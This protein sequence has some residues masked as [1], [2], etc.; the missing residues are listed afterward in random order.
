M[1]KDLNVT[2]LGAGSWGTT[3]AVHLDHKGCS[4]KLWEAFDDYAQILIETR[5]NEKYLPNTTIAPSIEI[6]SK[7]ENVIPE[8]DVIVVAI[9][10]QYVR[11]IFTSVKE[12]FDSIKA[13]IVSVSKGIEVKSLKR[14]S[15]MTSEFYPDLDFV[16]LSGPSHAEEVSRRIPTSVV[17]ASKNQEAAKIV[18]ELFMDDY[19]RVYTNKDVVGVELG[20]SLKNVIALACGI[21]DGLGFGDNSR[22]ALITRGLAEMTRLAGALGADRKTLS[23]LAGVGD[24]IVTCNS[25]HSRNR[26]VGRAIGEG[27]TL[28]DIL[29][30]MN[31]VAEGVETSKSVKRLGEKFGVE[32]P[33]CEQV[34]QVLFNHKDPRIAVRE[35]MLRDPKEE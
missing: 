20:G 3:L 5:V 14:I 19:F 4:V 25:E 13:T 34:Y 11:D 18:Q 2:I 6:T 30:H 10:T 7:L 15:E 9:P 1:P 32:M 35:L 12:K 28:T 33:I 21:S 27:K 23:G 29:T 26:R 8:A 22:A 24:L 17:A 31:M 16:V